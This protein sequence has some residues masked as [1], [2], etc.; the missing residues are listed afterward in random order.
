[1]NAKRISAASAAAVL[2]LLIGFAA[3][4]LV[5]SGDAPSDSSR[6]ELT[7]RLVGTKAA[8]EAGLTFAGLGNEETQ[9]R[10]AAE[11]ADR[12]LNEAQRKAVVD[13]I[14]AIHQTRSAWQMMSD[15]TCHR[16]GKFIDLDYGYPSGCGQSS[17][18][19]SPRLE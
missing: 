15:G 9:L 1:M 7:K 4:L 17:V 3:G 18:R 10:T 11:L 16:D 14:Y 5:R 13:A 8:I 19:L 6:Q 12:R 2:L